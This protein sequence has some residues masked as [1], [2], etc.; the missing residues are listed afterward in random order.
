MLSP[1]EELSQQ[2]AQA[3]ADVSQMYGAAVAQAVHL[4]V[5][6]N[7]QRRRLKKNLSQNPNHAAR[8][9]VFLVAQQYVGQHK[10]IEQLC[11]H[12]EAAAW[13]ELLPQLQRLAYRFLSRWGFAPAQIK[14][15][16]ADVAQDASIA[17]LSAHYP[18]DCPFT[19]WLT[20]IVHHVSRKHA[21]Q[22]WRSQKEETD[23][24]KSK[25]RSAITLLKT[26]LLVQEFAA[27]PE[28][29]T[30]ALRQ[31]SPL[32]QE[33]ILAHYVQHKALDQFASESG[34]APNTVYKRHHDALN[35]LRKILARGKTPVDRLTS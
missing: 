21:V 8:D 15:V 34:V 6:K 25:S 5:L 27:W 22:L 3:I 1:D 10:Y 7:W 19:A 16:T 35:N 14:S 23:L 11:L 28:E 24:E 12:K 31:L 30:A 18:Y 26:E 33:V 17:I 4:I 13:E 29:L 20:T 32:Q 2:L 9:Y